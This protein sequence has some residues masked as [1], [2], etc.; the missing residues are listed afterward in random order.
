M[1][2]RILPYLRGSGLSSL[3][4]ELLPLGNSLRFIVP[5]RKD[6]EW[7]F[8]RSGQGQFGPL[9]E[10]ED[11]LWTWQDLYDDIAS[12]PG[13]RSRRPISPPDHLLILRCLLQEALQGRPD[14]VKQW[15][16]VGRAGFLDILSNDV[17]ELMNEAVRPDQMETGDSP[18][19]A[20]LRDVYARFLD[21][22]H[23]NDL[24]DSAE[25][26]T[27]ASELLGQ[28]GDGWG[29]DLTLAFTGFL[30]FTHGQLELVKALETR[31]REIVIL[32]P[33]SGLENFY[34]ATEQ[35]ADYTWQL[36]AERSSGRIVETPVEEPSLEPEAVARTLALWAAGAGPL[37][38]VMDFPGFASIG[39]M[40]GPE[41][42]E[43]MTDAL[44]RYGVPFFPT[45]GVSIDRT[46]PGRIL[47]AIR[48]LDEQRFPT[49]DTIMLLTQPC[50]A[51][52]PFPS[53][54]TLR[55]GP[56]GLTGWTRY[57]SRASQDDPV[58]AAG[59]SMRAVGRLCRAVRKGGTPALLMAEFYRFL[60]AKGLWLDRMA[61]LSCP[62]LDE[63]VRTTASAIETVREKMLSLRELLPDIGPIGRAALKD[64][65]AFDFL[66]TWCRE[67]RTRPPMPLSG[68]LRLYAGQPP[69]LA[70]HSVWVMTGVTQRTW[71]GRS[72]S[73]P[74]LDASERQRLDRNGAHMPSPQEKAVQREALFR[75][76]LLTGEDLTLVYRSLTDDAGHPMAASP[77]VSR[78]LEDARGLW[79]RTELPV[80]PLESLTQCE[81]FFPDVDPDPGASVE[82][83]PQSLHGGER[84]ASESGQE[85]LA[86]SD[87]Q[88]LLSCPLRWWLERRARLHERR[89][90]VATAAEWGVLTHAFWERTW[91]RFA[92]DPEA[93]FAALT[94]EEWAKLEAADEPY[95]EYERFAEDRRLARRMG[96]LRFRALRL[97]EVQQR[98]IQRL[99]DAGF[100]HQG[101]WLEDDARLSTAKEGV[102]FHGRCDRVELLAGPDGRTCAVITDYKSRRAAIYDE[103]VKS[104]PARSWNVDGRDRF[105]FGLQLSAYALMFKERDPD[106]PLKGLCFLGMADGRTAGTLAPE[107]Q[108]LFAEEAEAPKKL[109]AS[110]EERMEEADCA[111]RCAATLLSAGKFEPFYD[112]PSCRV[113]DMKGICRRGEFHGE[114]LFVEDDADSAA[115]PE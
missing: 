59:A 9:D 23:R 64:R 62:E 33:E 113:C 42:M 19:A 27:A 91:R 4:R 48:L 107:L 99:R 110:M 81:D 40:A 41:G 34:D 47:S 14:L 45:L 54:R 94:R 112:S 50:F 16:G 30:S 78:L 37:A 68:A 46:L 74:L 105:R 100:R 32:K 102:T 21:Y 71:P 85:T 25:I 65:D 115:L 97:G 26:C 1:G 89:I 35:L 3:I 22:L 96:I 63:E 76:L 12:T 75:R 24:L 36:G 66:E 69:V 108:P 52:S 10:R 114:A 88:G 29:T 86:V 79:T 83:R 98:I 109:L 106:V 39:V 95:A 51:G 13:A 56:S 31:C 93:D 103:G 49:W 11:V 5:S 38:G 73:S 2:I 67:S 18:V 6:R 72:Q 70:S 17:Q 111:M 101:I 7:W 92:Q 58:K 104:L 43:D 57:L 28:L 44:T 61:D 60:T 20:L 8:L 82:R 87:L 55:A 77:F 53:E 90:E 15:P 84:S 80:V